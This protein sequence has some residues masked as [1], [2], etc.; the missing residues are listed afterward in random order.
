MVKVASP[1][2]IEI[3][4]P[5]GRLMA[6]DLAEIPGASYMELEDEA[7]HPTATVLIPFPLG[8][9]YLISVL[10]KPSALPT[11]TFTLR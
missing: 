11:D 6:R 9:E 5:D 10:P 2:D 8:G 4:A 1:V 7:G 3:T